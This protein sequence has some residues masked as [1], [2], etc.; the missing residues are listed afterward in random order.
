[1]CPLVTDCLK[2]G[3]TKITLHCR[4]Q[5]QMSHPHV[6]LPISG[7]PKTHVTVVTFV[8][9]E[10][11]V[12]DLDVFP[13]FAGRFGLLSTQGTLELFGGGVETEHG[14]DIDVSGKIW[15]VKVVTARGS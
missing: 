7:R 4:D 9:S 10:F 5:V 11:E 6:T 1:M 12:D 8:R 2:H 13:E 15:R 14:L 3:I